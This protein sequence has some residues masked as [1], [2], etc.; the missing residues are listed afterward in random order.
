MF[1]VTIRSALTLETLWIKCFHDED[2]AEKYA[3]NHF[4]LEGVKGRCLTSTWEPV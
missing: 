3:G 4:D 1:K 2:A